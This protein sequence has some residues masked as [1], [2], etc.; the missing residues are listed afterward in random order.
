MQ[1][2]TEQRGSAL[3]S[4]HDSSQNEAIETSSSSQMVGVEPAGKFMISRK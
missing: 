1:V 4:K 3:S 2:N